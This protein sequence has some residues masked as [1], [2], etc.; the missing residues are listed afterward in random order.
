M[1]KEAILKEVNAI[2][3]SGDY[4]KL[5]ALKSELIEDIRVEV[6]KSKGTKQK[7]IT[8]IKKIVKEEKL[9]KMC[10]KCHPFE[11]YG[12]S[13]KKY[14]GFLE[15]HYI[16]ASTNDFGYEVAEGNE[17]FKIDKMLTEF[18]TGTEITVDMVDLKAFIKTMDKK[19]ITPYI[20]DCNGVQ[21]GFNPKYLIDCLEFCNSD[22][23]Y[24]TTPSA[25]AY[26]MDSKEYNKIGL[27]L[28]IRL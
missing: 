11:F 8:I 15:G 25:P 21:I 13:N 16:L 18:G 23:I 24:C 2:I 22:K 7:D 5:D 28:P 3:N 17:L 6:E 14:Y 26:I 4:Y 27:V 9:N 10:G 12:T 20:I 19:D 1:T